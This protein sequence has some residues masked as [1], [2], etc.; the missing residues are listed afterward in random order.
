MLEKALKIAEDAIRK[1]YGE[2]AL[3][4]WA[5]GKYITPGQRERHRVWRFPHFP[6]NCLHRFHHSV[7]IDGVEALSVERFVHTDLIMLV[8]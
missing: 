3:P 2:D 7:Y 6:A 1:E 4:T 8:F 5:M